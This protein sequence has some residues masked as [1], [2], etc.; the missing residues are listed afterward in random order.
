MAVLTRVRTARKRYRC[1]L[2]DWIEPGEQYEESALTPGSDIG[3]GGWWHERRHLSE[4]CFMYA[5]EEQPGEDPGSEL[6]R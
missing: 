5:D 4:I 3:N 1:A 2:G 6:M